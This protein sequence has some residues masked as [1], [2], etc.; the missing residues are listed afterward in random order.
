MA[1]VWYVVIGI[2]LVGLVALALS[3]RSVLRRLLP[4]ANASVRASEVVGPALEVRDRAL[5]LQRDADVLLARMDGVS[6]KLS[7]VPHRTDGG[8]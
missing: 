7:G 6:G 5:A 2:V 8:H 3:A 4:L 1:L